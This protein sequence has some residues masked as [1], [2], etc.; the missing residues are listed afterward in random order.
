VI[1]QSL[2]VYRNIENTNITVFSYLHVNKKK[3]KTFFRKSAMTN[4]LKIL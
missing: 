1:V 4:L 3:K 2:Y